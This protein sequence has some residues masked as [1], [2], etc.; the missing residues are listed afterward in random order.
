MYRRKLQQVQLIAGPP[1]L[2]LVKSIC[3][4][5]V[6]SLSCVG[7]V[8]LSNPNEAWVLKRVFQVCRSNSQ[9]SMVWFIRLQQRYHRHGCQHTWLMSTMHAA[10]DPNPHHSVN[11]MDM[12]GSIP[13]K[14][15]RQLTWV[16]AIQSKVSTVQRL[17]TCCISI[18]LWHP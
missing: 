15:V 16:R 17:S 10:A 8:I 3:H 5:L 7:H 9:L 12:Y 4:V 13:S 1:C 6:K 18:A 2:V 11:I 14:H